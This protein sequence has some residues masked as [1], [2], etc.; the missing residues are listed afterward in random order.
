[1][2]KERIDR[3]N[4]KSGDLIKMPATPEESEALFDKEEEDFLSVERT[5]GSFSRSIP[6]PA[7]VNEDGAKAT[8]ENGLLTVVLPKAEPRRKSKIEIKGQ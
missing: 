1:M 5:Y 2:R 7:P 6:I 3:F 4:W 8:F